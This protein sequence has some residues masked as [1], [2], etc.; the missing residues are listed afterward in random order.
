M[1]GNFMHGEYNEN[2]LAEKSLLP[3]NDVIFHCLF[4]TVGN[5][6]I[7]KDLLEK[8]LNKKIENIELD[9]INYCY[10]IENYEN[11]ASNELTEKYLKIKD[12]CTLKDS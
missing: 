10:D 7:T 6:K 5:E 1:Q 11:I 3:T 12:T 2:L 8:L 9:R 4:G